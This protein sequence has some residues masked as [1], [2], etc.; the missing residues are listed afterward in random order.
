MRDCSAASACV[1]SVVDRQV[2]PAGSA[3]IRPR[4]LGLRRSGL[5]ALC[6]GRSLRHQIVSADALLRSKLAQSE[7]PVLGLRNAGLFA[8]HEL[9]YGVPRR[10]DWGVATA[11]VVRS[12]RIVLRAAGTRTAIAGR[13][14][15]ADQSEPPSEKYDGLTPVSYALATAD[16]QLD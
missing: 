1:P 11:A 13:L 16:R 4:A 15:R 12:C 9:E 8:M 5:F 7:Q 6:V 14:E 10:A 2:P 3:P